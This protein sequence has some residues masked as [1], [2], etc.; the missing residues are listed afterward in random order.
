MP[1]E[2][3]RLM[4]RTRN[5]PRTKQFFSNFRASVVVVR[6]KAAG[7][8]YILD[9]ESMSMG[10]GPGV[11]LTFPDTCMSRKHAILELVGEGFRIRDM[12]S[13]NGV[14]VN[15]KPVQVADLKHG[16][17]FELGEHALQYILEARDPTLR[18]YTIPDP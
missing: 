9:K 1:D 2:R 4:S 18:T 10:R 8:E 5:K 12:G 13:T 3:T 17:R 7:T 11:D 15:G 16:D 14:L 6:G